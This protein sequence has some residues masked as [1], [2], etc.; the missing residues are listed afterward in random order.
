MLTEYLLNAKHCCKWGFYVS[1]KN[2]NLRNIALY[3]SVGGRENSI[4]NTNKI[5]LTPSKKSD[6][7]LLGSIHKDVQSY[8]IFTDEPIFAKPNITKYSYVSFCGA[9]KGMEEYTPNC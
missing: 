4:L 3:K 2:L 1:A 7:D 8:R 5:L 9:G 6:I